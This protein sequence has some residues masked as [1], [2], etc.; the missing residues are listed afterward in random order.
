MRH[1]LAGLLAVAVYAVLA[2]ACR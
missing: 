2:G 1:P